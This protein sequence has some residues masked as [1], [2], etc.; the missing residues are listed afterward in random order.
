MPAVRQRKPPKAYRKS[1]DTDDDESKILKPRQIINTI[2]R[3]LREY[4]RR[5][6]LSVILSAT[7]VF[8]NLPPPKLSRHA[9]H[10]HDSG[11][12]LS[13]Q[14]HDVF[15]RDIIRLDPPV[16]F[17][18]VLVILHGFPSSS[19]DWRDLVPSLQ[20][21]FP[22]IVIPDLLGYGFS[23]KPRGSDTFEYSTIEQA[24][25]VE[26]LMI[27]LNITEAHVIAHDYGD[28]VAQELL[29]RSLPS[30]PNPLKFTL[31]SVCLTNGGIIPST[32]RPVLIQKLMMVPVLNSILA[33]TMNSFTF[34]SRFKPTFGE[35]T[36]PGDEHLSDLWSILLHKDGHLAVPSLMKHIPERAVHEERWVGA[37]QKTSVPLNLI[38]GPKDPVNKL[39]VFLPAYK[40]LVPKSGI[41]IVENAG[42][43][44]HV[45]DPQSFMN[46][47]NEFLDVRVGRDH[48]FGV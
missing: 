3:L 32:H 5:I 17:S 31:K 6:V 29:A 45:E 42:H 41:A 47:Y 21:R 10:W 43:H 37:L 40:T 23:D 12:K 19:Y 22:R 26:H 35:T 18:P 7:V 46:F 4:K 39:D 20:K 11:Y 15:Y 16:T 8:L 34:K 27:K 48:K 36:Q 38:Y 14:N 44:P 25:L 28:T 33:R 1:S 13:F 30:D 2:F 9:Q 24:S